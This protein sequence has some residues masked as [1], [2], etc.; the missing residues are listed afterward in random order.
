MREYTPDNLI[1]RSGNS[2]DPNVIV[3]VRPE[4]AGWNTIHFQARRL[5]AGQ[6]WTFETGDSELAL[7]T[8]LGTMDVESTRG[9]WRG[10]GGRTSV[11]AG[12][13][14]ALYLPRE[15]AFTVRALEAGEFAAAWVFTDRDYPP[16]VVTPGQVGIEIRG[17]GNATRQINSIIPPGFPCGRLVVVEVYTPGG[18]WSSYP[19]HKHDVHAAAPDGRLLEA[20]LDEVYYY[21]FDRPEGYALQRIYTGPDSPLHRAGRPIDAAVTARE[22]DVVLIPEGYHPVSSPVGYMTYYLNVLAG[23]AQSLACTDD[24]RYA[25]IKETYGAPDPRVPVYETTHAEKP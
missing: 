3:E 8:L 15:T 5:A 17:G 19:P 12:L 14:H 16:R 6:S 4:L 25:W 22:H 2:A 9:E 11:F 7:V 23:S 24:P 1:V 10:L 13:P 20:D 18:N 21:R